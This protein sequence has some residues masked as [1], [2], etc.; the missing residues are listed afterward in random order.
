MKTMLLLCALVVGGGSVWAGTVT[1]TENFAS[2]A[3]SNDQYDCSSAIS[4]AANQ[5]DWDY[6]WTPSGSGTVFKSGIKLGKSN[7]TGTVTNTTMLSGISTGTSITIKV[8]AAQWNT[9]GGSLVVT[10]NSKSETKAPANSAITSTSNTYSSSDFSNS[11][12]FTITKVSDVTSFSIASS[13]KRILIDKVEVIY[14]EN[15]S[16]L[17]HISLSGTYPTEFYLG[18]TFSH[19]GLIVTAYYE[20]SSTANVTGNATFE[21]YNMNTLGNQT[22]T[23]SYTTGGVTKTAQYG[24]TVVPVPEPVV[25]LDFTNAGWG[26]PSD[27]DTSEKTYTNKGY[28]ITLGEG[29]SGHKKLVVSSAT[30]SLIFGK[31]NA[32]LTLPAFGFKVS[33]LKVYGYSGAGAKVTFNVYVGADAVST[34]ATSSQETHDFVIAADKQNVG[35]IYTIKVTNANNCQISKIEIFGNGCEAGIVGNAGWATYVTEAPV[36]YAEGDAFAVTS[37]GTSVELTSVTS[38]RTGTPLLLKGAGQKTAILL[39]AEPAAITNKLA[40]SDGDD[41]KN[42][43]VLANHNSKVGF[44]KWT[45]SALAFGKVYL[46]ASEVAGAREFIGFDDEATGIANINGEAKTLFNGEFYNIAGQRVAQPNKG[47]Y[48]VNGKKVIIK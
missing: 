27:Y 26:F 17:H 24:I 44:Y 43:Y 14:E 6:A 33:R 3:A 18:D 12:N 37:V 4:T 35:T 15:S 7:G 46:P 13:A 47:L 16:P 29:S 30:V 9:D 34:E 8:Y 40:V 25:T 11:T 31:E 28:T 38:V 36:T 21:G 2:S 23:V 1:R 32:T 10:Y 5:T 20:D 41:G 48:I 22:V 39:D 45:G 19:D 42:D